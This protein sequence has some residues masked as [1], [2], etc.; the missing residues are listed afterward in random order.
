MATTLKQQEAIPASYPAVTPY[1]HWSDP[2]GLNGSFGHIENIEPGV[3]WQRMESWI[4]YRWGERAV[5]WTVEGG[6][7]WQAPLYPA[8]ITTFEIWENDAWA[9]VSLTAG[10][11]G[12]LCTTE[13]ETYRITATVGTSDDPPAAIVEAWRRL[14]E[15]SRGIAEQFHD[16]FADIE[17]HGRTRIAAFAA[18]AISL[19][20]AADL[21]KPYRRP[22]NVAI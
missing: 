5:T 13:G 16:E 8:T 6:G 7:E 2:S 15:Y 4:A 21:L 20:G 9:E 22:G 12:G 1:E 14:H 3:I 10:P 17:S 11:Y 18:K 19:S